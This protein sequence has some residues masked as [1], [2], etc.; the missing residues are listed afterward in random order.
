MQMHRKHAAITLKPIRA[1][2]ECGAGGRVL[3]QA[4][5][6]TRNV[7]FLIM[8]ALIINAFLA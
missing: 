7:W 5:A 6:V 2:N 4:F 8:N 3:K 1:V